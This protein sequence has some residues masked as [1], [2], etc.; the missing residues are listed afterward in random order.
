L[1]N[2]KQ[3]FIGI[4]IAVGLLANRSGLATQPLV[5]LANEH[6]TE[7]TYTY[8]FE[9]LPRFVESGLTAYDNTPLADRTPL[10][11][12]HGIAAQNYRLF[13]WENF[14]AFVDKRPDFKRQYK[15]YLYH[16]DSSQSVKDI[17]GN[18]QQ[19]LKRFIG[20]LNGRPIKILAY[21]EGGLL[22]RNAMQDPYVYSHTLKVLTIATPFHGSPLAN[23]EWVEQQ[24]KTEP[25]FNVIRITQKLA[26]KITGKL[27][28]SFRE[29][30]H[31]DNFDGA[32]PLKQYVKNNGPL[33]TQ[34]YALAHKP[35]FITYGSYFGLEAD[36]NFLMQELELK[37]PPPKEKL[38]IGNLFR[39]NVLFSLIRNNIGKL[40]LAS[41]AE[42]RALARNDGALK[43]PSP[44]AEPV[45]QVAEKKPVT[46]SVAPALAMPLVTES[47]DGAVELSAQPEVLHA[48]VTAPPEPASVHSMIS[49]SELK[50]KPRR[51]MV[52]MMMYND[53]ISPISSTLWLGR[54][55]P[56]LIGTS[57]PV[58][59]LWAT[60]KSLR[61]NRNTRLFA[62][63]DH[64]NW[65]DGDTR[66]GTTIV[67]DLLNPDQK[68]RPVFEW[69]ID[70]L[71]S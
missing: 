14:L 5:P 62:G 26:Y 45:E 23:P 41:P 56:N 43:E 25:I 11:L 32:I 34:D 49:A 40:P 37:N 46:I 48:K 71:M 17:S 3:W 39:K 1:F 35:D 19:T 69:I 28:P 65:M 20:G 30:F 7:W 44:K 42:Q 55:T 18:F 38:M 9:Q 2:K 8:T 57:Q 27:Y 29:D 31:W 21:S 53:G 16:Y 24:V 64:R 51:P 54:Y 67:Q 22:T 59:K 61:G 52:S 58:E 66:T 12:V 6:K 33:T 15:I 60:L 47:A 50:M 70:D 13:N 68:P 36:S 10:I 4:L 63:I